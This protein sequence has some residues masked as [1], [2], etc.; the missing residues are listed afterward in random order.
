MP[1][2]VHETLRHADILVHAGS[3]SAH[4]KTIMSRGQQQTR[5]TSPIAPF[6]LLNGFGD[7]STFSIAPMASFIPLTVDQP[8]ETLI[9]YDVIRSGELLPINERVAELFIPAGAQVFRW[10][11]MG[12]VARNQFEL[13]NRGR[14][15]NDLRAQ[16]STGSDPWI[17]YPPGYYRMLL[18][19]RQH[20][21]GTIVNADGT[22]SPMPPVLQLGLHL[23]PT[24]G[25]THRDMRTGC[26]GFN[27]D[28]RAGWPG[29]DEATPMVDWPVGASLNRGN[30]SE[31]AAPKPLLLVVE[32]I[33]DDCYEAVLQY[34]DQRPWTY[35]AY[36]II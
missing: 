26:T 34:M 21:L 4:G 15:F 8:K 5:P 1:C 33:S 23:L 28:Q 35:A 29:F 20:S 10:Q 31:L 19:R 2:S 14:V 25:I 11:D 30:M 16:R 7:Y 12:G 6:P 27:V 3:R 13:Q 17:I 9:A 32:S 22:A 24:Y 18:Q 36:K